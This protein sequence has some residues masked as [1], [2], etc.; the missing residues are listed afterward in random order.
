MLK[1]LFFLCCVILVVAAK[2]V[3][4]SPILTLDKD[5]Q[6]TTVSGFFKILIKTN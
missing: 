5:D 3:D 6:I 1:A 2:P 4:D